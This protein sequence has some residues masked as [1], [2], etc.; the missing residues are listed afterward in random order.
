LTAPGPPGAGLDRAALG[1]RWRRLAGYLD[2]LPEGL[3]SYPS[4]QAR[5]GVVEAVLTAGP[6]VPRDAPP[7]VKELLTPPTGAWIPEV[8]FQAGLLAMADAAGWSDD[9]LLAWHRSLN[10]SLFKGPVY[11]ALM[12]FFSPLLLLEKGANRWNAFH[13]GSSLAVTTEGKRAALATLTFPPG[14]F[15]PL[16]LRVYAGAFAAALEHARAEEVAVE[17]AEAGETWG[18]FRAR[19]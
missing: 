9:D 19:W 3:V 11:R 2:G 14:L 4:C 8:A 15:T 18:R 6:P 13:Q 10:R 7:G 12:A 5:R 17:V 16:L 1:P